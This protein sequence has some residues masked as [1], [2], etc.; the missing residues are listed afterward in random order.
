MSHFR[1]LFVSLCLA[2]ILPALGHAHASKAWGLE[3]LT[4]SITPTPSA[5]TGKGWALHAYPAP[6]ALPA[7]YLHKG[8][9][10]IAS[11]VVARPAVSAARHHF[12]PYH[13]GSGRAAGSLLLAVH[14]FSSKQR[15]DFHGAV[16]LL[17]LLLA[18][19]LFNLVPSQ[20]RLQAGWPVQWPIRPPPF[21]RS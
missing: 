4:G 13:L 1:A 6:H 10:G 16:W 5:Q 21:I 18:L 8:K 12:A 15:L 14:Q 2:A 11:A 9:G 7:P 19:Q 3:A 20:R 17:A